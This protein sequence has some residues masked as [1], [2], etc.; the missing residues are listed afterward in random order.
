MPLT[1]S[2]RWDGRGSAQAKSKHRQG[3]YNPSPAAG[4]TA[5]APRRRLAV[6]FTAAG[7][8]H[9]RAG[10]S[11]VRWNAYSAYSPMPTAMACVQTLQV[12]GFASL[13]RTLGLRPGSPT[14]WRVGDRRARVGSPGSGKR[15]SG[16]IEAHRQGTLGAGRFAGWHDTLAYPCG[17][18]VSRPRLPLFPRTLPA[19]C[20]PFRIGT[21][22]GRGEI[23]HRRYA[24][25]V[26][27]PR[28]PSLRKGRAD[29]VQGLS[30]RL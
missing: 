8:R 29:Q 1:L 30:R 25:P 6:G 19:A 24:T 5:G 11:R 4:A 7:V 20:G 27:S 15:A 17:G 2:R 23:P 14:A 12:A 10:V 26:A 28:A 9:P 13:R 18:A 16:P 21:F 22:S 3:C